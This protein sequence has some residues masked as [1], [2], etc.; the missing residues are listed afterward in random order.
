MSLGFLAIVALYG[1]IIAGVAAGI[2][3]GTG[4]TV[5]LAITV[6]CAA[7]SAVWF[8]RRQRLARVDGARADR[9]G[10]RETRWYLGAVRIGQAMALLLAIVAIVGSV[11]HHGGL[12]RLVGDIIA[13]IVGVIFVG[14]VWATGGAMLVA[15]TLSLGRE[16]PAE[17][18]ARLRVGTGP[19]GRTAGPE[20]GRTNVSGPRLP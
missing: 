6:V 9:K 8:V 13:L 12:V 11:T 16:L 17:R 19:T 4:M 18:Q 14:T 5:F 3:H 1:G 20:P 2:G 10:L 7:W 15:F